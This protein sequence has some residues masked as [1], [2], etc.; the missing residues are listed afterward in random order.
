MAGTYH[1]HKWAVMM[2][3]DTY[4]APEAHSPCLTGFRDDETKQIVTSTIVSVQGR[5]VTTYSGSTYI[6]EDI[7]SEYLRWLD[8]NGYDLDPDNPIKL[9]KRK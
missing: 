7:S 2:Y 4:T 6:L 8:E 5:E 3:G 9:I 1:L